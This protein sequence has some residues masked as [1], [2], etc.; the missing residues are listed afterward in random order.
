MGRPP[1][2]QGAARRARL[3]ADVAGAREAE[4]T[5]RPVRGPGR[6]RVEVQV[7]DGQLGMLGRAHLADEGVAGASSSGWRA[8]AAPSSEL[9]APGSVPTGRTGCGA[10]Q[11]TGLSPAAFVPVEDCPAGSPEVRALLRE[12]V[13]SPPPVARGSLRLRVGLD[14]VRGLWLDADREVL[15]DL[16][17][18]GSPLARWAEATLRAGI[19]LEVGQRHEALALDDGRP[20]QAVGLRRVAALRRPWG[21]TYVRGRPWPLLTRLGDFS[22]PSPE[23]N[24]A[25]LAA[26]LDLA[27]ATGETRWLELGAGAGNMTLPLLAEGFAVRAVEPDVTALGENLAAWSS[28][29]GKRHSGGVCEPRVGSLD[30]ASEVGSW[31]IGPAPGT[32]SR[33]S[34][35]S[36]AFRAVLADPPRSGLGA[37]GAA[38]GGLSRTLRPR[39]ILYVS[40][41]H[42]ALVRDAAVLTRQGYR[43]VE[44]VGVEQFRDSPE[45]EWVTLWRDASAT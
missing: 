2:A 24:R 21:Q 11:P 38:L 32:N 40:C 8:P 5:L 23:G 29:L 10:R 9:A 34:A 27:R 25:L 18:A 42:A 39:V 17:R 3:L 43:L 7:R 37:F 16:A 13:A 4:V 41:W 15:R 31:L 12:V 30:R 44:A 36:K 19:V 6:T 14:G 28:G 35:D 1:E 26:V 45:V 20:D 22:Q 33:G